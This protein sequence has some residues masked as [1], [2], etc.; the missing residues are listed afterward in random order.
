MN[1]SFLFFVLMTLLGG[2]NRLPAVDVVF[3]GPQVGEQLPAFKV[4]GVLGDAA[5]KE[6][7][8]VTQ[9]AGKPLVLIF[10]HDVNRQSIGM[11]RTLS[12]YTVGREQDGLHTGVIL[13]DDD[14]TAAENTLKRISHAL[15]P[16]APTGVSPDGR[17][18]PGAYGL[19]RNVMLTILVGK[20]GKVTANFALVQPSLQVDLPKI[21]DEVVK[22]AGGKAPKLEELAGMPARPAANEQDPN[23]RGLLTPVI[24]RDA[25][26]EDVDRAAKR[27]EEYVA[28]NEATRKEVGRI[29]NTI[30]KAGKLKDYGTPRAQEYLQ[31]WAK[32]FGTPAAEAPQKKSGEER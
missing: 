7:D 15:T 11:L 1:R 25:Q 29:A 24:R 27:V 17:E 2:A 6:L 32:E 4:R 21:L 8:F 26:P 19:N 5:G 16:K 9:A 23:L 31:K 14:A 20:D 3:S 28:N 22:V 18:G 30:I 12:G 10:L 13:L